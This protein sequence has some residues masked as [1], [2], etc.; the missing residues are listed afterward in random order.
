MADIPAGGVARLAR[1]SKADQVAYAL[2]AVH[3][4]HHPANQQ[5]EAPKNDETCRY[6][7]P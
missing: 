2:R 6:L 5:A 7:R 1:R 3:M 4:C